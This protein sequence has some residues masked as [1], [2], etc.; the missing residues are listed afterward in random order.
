[1]KQLTNMDVFHLGAGLI[2]LLMEC[3][4]LTITRNSQN[5]TLEELMMYFGSN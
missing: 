1:M 5:S 3:L 2:K 4:T